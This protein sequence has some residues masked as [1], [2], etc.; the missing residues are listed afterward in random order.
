MKILERSC[1]CRQKLP[2]WVSGGGA[3]SKPIQQPWSAKST[4]FQDLPLFIY[5]EGVAL[6]DDRYLFITSLATSF[7]S[8][9]SATNRRVL[10]N[11]CLKKSN[12]QRPASSW[13]KSLQNNKNSFLD[14]RHLTERRDYGHRHGNFH[15]HVT[16]VT[17]FDP[18]S[19]QT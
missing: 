1:F 17:R 11:E 10:H 5:R 18:C 12:E 13:K 7:V 19:R 8:K 4:H 3:T 16:K 9:R 2:N 15:I 14:V 6:K